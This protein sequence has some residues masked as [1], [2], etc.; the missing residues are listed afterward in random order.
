[1]GDAAAGTRERD[2]STTRTVASVLG[3]RT[4]EDAPGGISRST[5]P[6]RTNEV[7]AE[8]LLGDADTFVEACRVARGA[9]AG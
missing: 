5:N 9:Q 4:L 8:V 7:V 3:G 2:A 1:M 6:A